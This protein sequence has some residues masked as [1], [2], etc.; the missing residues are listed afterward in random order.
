MKKFFCLVFLKFCVQMTSQVPT[1]VVTDPLME[2]SKV[3]ING[4]LLT[5]IISKQIMIGKI[6]KLKELEEEYNERRRAKNDLTS[7]MLAT[8]VVGLHL[9]DQNRISDMES[10]LDELL[11]KSLKTKYGLFHLSD[12]QKDLDDSSKEFADRYLKDFIL[13][14]LPIGDIEHG[15]RILSYIKSIH[16][17]INQMETSSETKYKTNAMS[18]LIDKLKK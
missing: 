18:T 14:N 2:A 8:I 15:D 12:E 3:T 10:K 1:F 13:T 5:Q 17:R 7:V 11:A 6:N 16:L 4:S 9:I